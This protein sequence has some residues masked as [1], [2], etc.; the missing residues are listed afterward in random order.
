M[1]IFLDVTD[2]ICSHGINQRG[3]LKLQVI[4]LNDPLKMVH[5]STDVLVY[6]NGCERGIKMGGGKPMH[7]VELLAELIELEIN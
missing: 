3:Y 5:R 1:V 6:C 2:M 4:W 7:I